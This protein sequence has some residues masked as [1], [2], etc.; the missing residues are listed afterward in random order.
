M[1]SGTERHEELK[2]S[3]N[4][5]G[6]LSFF[7]ILKKQEVCVIDLPEVLHVYQK[8]V[9]AVALQIDTLSEVHEWCK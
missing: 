7:N 5:S 2:I 8:P 9:L 6:L 4:Y 1:F 3:N